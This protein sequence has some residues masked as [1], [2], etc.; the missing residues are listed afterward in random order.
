MA[1]PGWG[2]FFGGIGAIIGR[3]ST[4]IPGKIEKLKNEKLKLEEERSQIEKI[5][6]DITNPEHRKKAM[7]LSDIISRIKYID[8]MLG[9]KAQD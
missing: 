3:V 2:T 9:N 1:M 4:Y 5:N 8:G 6:M 7:R